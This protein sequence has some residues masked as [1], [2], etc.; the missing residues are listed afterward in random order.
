M[1][2]GGC[3]S[4][5]KDQHFSLLNDQIWEINVFICYSTSMF[6]ENPSYN[7]PILVLSTWKTS[8]KNWT[9]N[10]KK[11]KTESAWKPLWWGQNWGLGFSKMFG[12]EMCQWKSCHPSQSL[13]WWHQVILRMFFNDITTVWVA[14]KSS[15]AAFS[16]VDG[17]RPAVCQSAPLMWPH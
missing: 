3:P 5:L 6:S 15:S 7:V 13:A 8:K 2:L 16:C 4:P 12:G 9:F 10:L 1:A 11:K 14:T 17:I